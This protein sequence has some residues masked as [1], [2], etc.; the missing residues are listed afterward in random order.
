MK[1]L[2]K[3]LAVLLCLTVLITLLGPQILLKS[4]MQPAVE[5]EYAYSEAFCTTYEQVRERL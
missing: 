2:W 5:T 1:N 4:A 3:V